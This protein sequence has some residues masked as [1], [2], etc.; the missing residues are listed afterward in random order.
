[1][2]TG[3]ANT[4]RIAGSIGPSA[5]GSVSKFRTQDGTVDAP[6]LIADTAQDKQAFRE[7]I[8]AASGRAA[9]AEY[10]VQPLAAN[11]AKTGLPIGTKANVNGDWVELVASSDDSNVIHFK[12]V[13]IDS[14]YTGVR[15]GITGLTNLGGTQDPT[16]NV[17]VGYAISAEQVALARARLDKTLFADPNVILDIQIS[18]PGAFANMSLDRQSSLDTAGATGQY[19]F[20][21]GTT[22]VRFDS[23]VGGD[24]TVRFWTRA[25]E[26][27][28]QVPLAVHTANRWELETDRDRM[29]ENTV[30]E[31][32]T[33]ANSGLQG[34]EKAATPNAKVQLQLADGVLDSISQEGDVTTIGVHGDGED[35]VIDTSS[36]GG[37]LSSVAVDTDNMRGNGTASNPLDVSEHLEDIAGSFTGDGW[38]DIVGGSAATQIAVALPTD[39]ALTATTIVSANYGITQDTSGQLKN[40]YQQVR[41]PSAHVAQQRAQRVPTGDGHFLVPSATNLVTTAGGFSYYQEQIDTIPA[42]FTIRPQEFS[43]LSLDPSRSLDGVVGTPIDQQIRVWSDTVRAEVWQ[44]LDETG[45]AVEVADPQYVRLP[46]DVDCPVPTTYVAEQ[47]GDWQTAYTYTAAEAQHFIMFAIMAAEAK[48]TA[49]GGGDRAGIEFRLRH[50]NSSNVL[51]RSI[52]RSGQPYLRHNGQTGSVQL[53]E[54]ITLPL[55]LIANLS[56]DDYVQIQGRGISQVDLAARTAPNDVSVG[57]RAVTIKADATEIMIQ[58]MSAVPVSNATI[59]ARIDSERPIR[60]ELITETAFQALVTAGTVDA[61]TLYGRYTP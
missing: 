48:W 59:D 4:V 16:V 8:G 10:E 14:T 50:F 2:A 31:I 41:I 13:T 26:Q 37:G 9:G 57:D 6:S 15:Q 3:T 23:P 49:F 5:A 29:R 17:E 56:A 7:R 43:K 12:A 45:G 21:A 25:N 27:A 19:G 55:P 20:T 35:V 33:D 32:E 30:V 60:I 47:W 44:S 1:M 40:Y 46:S 61:N 36:T 28:A 52:I 53:A 24:I 11:P 34:G 22:G 39:T 51:Q 42:S 38:E 58:T 54:M 18:G